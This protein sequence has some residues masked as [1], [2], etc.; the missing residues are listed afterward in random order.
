[1]VTLNSYAA[2][3]VTIVASVEAIPDSES[4]E[5]WLNEEVSQ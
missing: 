5:D 1:M 4:F 2:D 3:G